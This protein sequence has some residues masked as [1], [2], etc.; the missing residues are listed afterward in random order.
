MNWSF[1]RGRRYRVTFLPAGARTRTVEFDG[2]YLGVSGLHAE[3]H[4]FDCRPQMGTQTIH[5]ENIQTVQEL[6]T[7]VW[8]RS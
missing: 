8:A 7:A 1:T 4:E 5:D 6:G 3:A 2:N